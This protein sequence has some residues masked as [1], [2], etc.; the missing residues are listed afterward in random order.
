VG[1]KVFLITADGQTVENPRHS[2]KAEQPLKQAQRRVARRKQ[3]STRRRKA[4]ALLKRT[5][6]PVRRQRRAF[7]HKTARTLLRPADTIALD[8]VRVAN[9]LR[10][11]R[12]AKSISDA[13][14]A[15][16]RT[17]LAG[18]AAYAGRRIVAVPPAFTAQDCSGGGERVAKSLWV[19]THVCI[20]CGLTLDR[21]ENAARNIL[22]LGQQW[23]GQ[24]LRGLA[25]MPAALN[26]EASSL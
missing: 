19:R 9:M 12:L 11:H 21:D 25:G 23:A 14:W 22:T 13:S 4:A 1:L 18:K 6:Q 15:A 5:Q 17:I 8:D 10:N 24:A 7:H 3:G 16:F 20:T 26:R 2:P